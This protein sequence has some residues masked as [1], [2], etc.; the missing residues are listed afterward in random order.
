MPK[1]AKRGNCFAFL[2]KSV[3]KAKK[4]CVFWEKFLSKVL[5]LTIVS[6]PIHYA[7]L[8]YVGNPTVK[9]AKGG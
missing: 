4:I 7:Q 6:P 3:K 2:L 5:K 8:C 9:S 1:K